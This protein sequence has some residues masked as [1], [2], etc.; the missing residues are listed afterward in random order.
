MADRIACYIM[1]GGIG[2][3]LWP[4][5][6]EDN[7][8]QFH[9]FTGGGSMIAKTVRRLRARTA[10]D[11]PVYM[12]AASRHAGRVKELAASETLGGGKAIFEPIGRNTAA[13]VAVATL[14]TIHDFGDGLVLVVPSDQEISP[15]DEF[16]RT[17][18]AGIGTANAGRIVVFGIVPNHP[19]TG[20]GYIEARPDGGEG[21]RAVR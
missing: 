6:R 2:S 20:F 8:K 18:E 21:G 16:W 13:A 3:R 5:S 12:I 19:A 14:Q 9:D 10:G 1:S 7:P 4:L 15:D 17:I 11:A